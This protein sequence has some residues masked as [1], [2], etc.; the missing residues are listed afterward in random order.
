MIADEAAAFFQENGYYVVRQAFTGSYLEDLR[1]CAKDV[2]A[3]AEAS[4]C[5][6]IR[7]WYGDSVSRD[8]LPPHLDPN[9]YTWG[10]NEI[11]RPELFEPLLIN[12]I[13]S[14]PLVSVLNAIMDEPRAWGQKILW[15]PRKSEYDLFWHRDIEHQYDN[16]LPWKPNKNDHVQFNAALEP[17]S[18]FIVVPQSHRRAIL[19]D[20]A[21]LIQGSL[22]T[23]LSDQI[24]VELEPGDVVCMDAHA[25][26]RGH[27][28][29]GA[30]RLSLHYSFQAQWV[31][32]IPWGA[33]DE[34]DWICSEEFISQLD[35]AVQPMYRRLPT[36]ERTPTGAYHLHWL[37]DIA[38]RNGWDGS[39]SDAWPKSRRK[40]KPVTVG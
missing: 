6:G 5:S 29:P 19:A 4:R 12:A 34:F 3:R 36:A 2:R 15:A 23:E 31:P 27:A 25:I 22:T 8:A 18:S 16:L 28:L 40:K 35:P 26:H 21:E 13:G 38:R 39:F 1:A 9:D 37:E 17:D 24:R 10:V 32:L 7:H 11:T 33:D 20:E 30:P 14:E